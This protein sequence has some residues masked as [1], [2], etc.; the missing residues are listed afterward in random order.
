MSKIR[1]VI[2]WT[3]IVGALVL[4]GLSVAKII[5]HELRPRQII[6]IGGSTFRADVVDTPRLRE[7]G[8]SG[9][10]GLDDD[11]AMLFVFDSD[12]KWSFWMKE[13]KFPIDI[14]WLNNEGVVNY[15]E[16]DVKPDAIPHKVYA[17]PE[18]ARYVIELAAGR[19][20]ELG[21]KPGTEVRFETERRH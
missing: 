6:T 14:I 9:R 8:L 7:K 12:D 19:A 5:I 10:S 15:V 13:M 20:G 16:Y 1:R 11:E 2:L 4:I 18:P 3:I 17:P 21:I